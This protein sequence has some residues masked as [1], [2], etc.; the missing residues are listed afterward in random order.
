MKIVHKREQGI[1]REWIEE[2]HCVHVRAIDKIFME[3]WVVCCRCRCRQFHV[4]ICIIIGKRRRSLWS[5]ISGNAS[6]AQQFTI[7]FL[8]SLL[9]FFLIIG[10][11]STKE[12]HSTCSAFNRF[13]FQM[14]KRKKE[15][16]NLKSNVFSGFLSFRSVCLWQMMFQYVKCKYV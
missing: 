16:S 13:A 10:F 7:D 14:Q 8:H 3:L 9:N 12:C 5:V 1:E 15:Y 2:R 4:G 11:I 6:D